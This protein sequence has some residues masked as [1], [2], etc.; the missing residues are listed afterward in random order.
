M[1]LFIFSQGRGGRSRQFVLPHPVAWGLLGA[2]TLVILGVSFGFGIELEQ[3]SERQLGPHQVAHWS[4]VLA[5]QKAEVAELRQRVHERTDA[6]AI[7]LARLD[8]HIVRIDEL[9]KRLA[10]MAH[11]ERSE[12][13]F[14]EE[15]AVGGPEGNDVGGTPQ[16]PD[17]SSSIDALGHR[18][19]LRDAQLAALENVLLK[20]NLDAAVQPEGRPVLHGFI[21][22][23]YGDRDDPFTGRDE[24]HKGVDFAGT[25]GAQ[26]VAVAA[27]VVTWVGPRSG[28]GNVVEINHG[29][30]YVTRYAHNERVLVTV[31]QTVTRGQVIALMGSTGRSTGP[32]VHFEVLHDGKQV[33][34]L[35]FVKR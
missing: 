27:G 11:I 33:N 10:S 24:F 35:K 34:P 5:A 14:D 9:G 17:L 1:S 15:P 21:S 16:I 32:H 22:S 12:F 25:E 19:D 30:G 4:H 6:L 2:A 23:Y 3:H 13:N 31:G 20:R 29:K 7:R 18:I 28:Y 8:A 26:V